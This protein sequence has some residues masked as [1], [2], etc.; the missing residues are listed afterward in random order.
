MDP[1]VAEEWFR[2]VEHTTAL[3][4]MTDPEKIRY[5]SFLFRGDAR[6]WW[7]LM[8]DTHEIAVMT[9]GEFRRLFEAE[10]RTV[11]RVHEKI[12]EFIGLQQGTGTVK[13]YLVKFIFLARS[14]LGV[15]STPELRRDKFVHGLK[16]EIARDVMAGAEP[17]QTYSEA[18]E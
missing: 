6:I 1:L 3:F 15:V 4:P 14:V 5:A 8:E 10:Y 13:E 17:L 11:D 7:E 16:P 18:L 2:S 12:Q 9:W